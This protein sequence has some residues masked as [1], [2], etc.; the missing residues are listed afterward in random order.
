MRSSVRID[1]RLSRTPRI[2]GAYQQYYTGADAPNSRQ[3]PQTTHT[4]DLTRFCVCPQGL[5][6]AGAIDSQCFGV[7][8]SK[9]H[10][11]F[12]PG[13]PDRWVGGAYQQCYTCERPRDG[14]LELKQSVGT[15]AQTRQTTAQPPIPANHA[16]PRPNGILC[17]PSGA[18]AHGRYQLP[19][20]RS[21]RLQRQTRGVGQNVLDLLMDAPPRGLALVRLDLAARPPTACKRQPPYLSADEHQPGTQRH[22]GVTKPAFPALG[23]YH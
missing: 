22:L 13:R 3:F 19:R 1:L 6:H 11:K 7:A 8:D 4:P 21:R 16:H 20:F 9:L 12:G 5:L 2:G 18:S 23:R 14:A 17:L 15:G 10:L